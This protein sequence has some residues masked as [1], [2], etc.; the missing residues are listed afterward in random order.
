MRHFKLLLALILLIPTA[1]VT[2]LYVTQDSRV[3][4]QT[5]NTMASPTTQPAP[6]QAL[7]ITTPD[8]LTLRGI[9]FPA[10]TASPTLI[11]AFAGNAH[12][13]V[14]FASFLKNQVFPQPNV[15]VAGLAYRGYPNGLGETSD[16][17]PSEPALKA[18]ATLLY[19][20]LTTQLAPSQIHAIGYSL[21]S[22]VA[23]HLASQRDLTTLTLVAPPA[24]IRR[25]A[26]E[27]YPWLPV[28]KLLK[29]PWATE[30]IIGTLNLPITILHTTTDGLIPPTHAHI[31]Q[32][33][34]PQAELIN[35]PNTK[36]GTVLDAPSIPQILQHAMRVKPARPTSISTQPML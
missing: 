5:I 25:L 15:A 33:Q 29:S 11:L 13:A 14:G 21:G 27:Q 32:Q 26:Q 1:A 22:A 34:A 4:P 16:G 10:Q 3:Y 9:L 17:T 24:S 31:L 19:D 7:H 8:A 30:D 23:T 2:T 28:E 35:I 18:D 6:F 36:H 20:T 12:D